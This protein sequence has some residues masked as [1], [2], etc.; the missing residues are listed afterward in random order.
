MF[1]KGGGGLIPNANYVPVM[2][3]NFS[4]FFITAVVVVFISFYF[5]IENGFFIIVISYVRNKV[6]LTYL[7]TYILFLLYL[8]RSTIFDELVSQSFN[9]DMK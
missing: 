5:V 4:S 6:L 3:E 2:L 1:L 8:L 9:L 7:L